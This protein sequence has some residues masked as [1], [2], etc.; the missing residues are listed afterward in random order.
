MNPWKPTPDL[1]GPIIVTAKGKAKPDGTPKDVDQEFVALFMIFDELMAQ[2][3]PFPQNLTRFK[4]DPV[5]ET[6]LFHAINGYVFGN[7]PGLIVKSG[8]RVRW[9]LLGMGSQQDVHTAH[10]HGK[11][12]Q[13]QSRRT[14]V[15]EL[16]P[17]S[18]VSV[19]MLADNPGTWL[20]HCQVTDHM[21]AGMM[22]TY[23]I[24]PPAPKSCPV[25]FVSGEFWK[26][27]RFFSDHPKFRAPDHPASGAHAG[28]VLVTA[29]LASLGD[30]V[31]MDETHRPGRT[32]HDHHQ[33]LSPR[34]RQHSGLGI[35]SSEN[36]VR[37]RQHL[38]AGASARVLSCLLA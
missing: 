23:S 20:F 8:D 1:L 36:R 30:L 7:L 32:G 14:D 22:A 11:T 2:H 24:V 27:R 31:D 37:R 10:W 28:N 5:D 25:K 38:D 17:A 3:P 33:G 16:L 12:V 21:E 26:G 19:D 35:F 34:Q 18:M 9:H 29:G 15:V 4:R 13:Y 6:G